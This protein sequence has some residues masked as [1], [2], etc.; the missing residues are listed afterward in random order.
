MAST[1]QIE[2][3]KDLLRISGTPLLSGLPESARVMPDPL[4]I[5]VYLQFTAPSPQARL[6]FQAGE[7]VESLHFTCCH[8]Y[9]PYWMTI[10]TGTRGGQVPVETQFLL[11]E[12]PD[13]TVVL[14]VPLLNGP[15]RCS[16]QGTGEDGLELVAES[17]DPAVVTD[18]VTGL[19]IAAGSDPYSLVEESAGS[20]MQHMGTGRLRSEKPLPDFIDQFG[21]CTWDAF[22]Q[23]V[24][25]EKVRQGLES[26]VRGGIL[27]RL[28]ILDDGWQ[29]EQSMPTGERRLTS[30]AANDKFPGGLAPTV[31]MA[32]DEFGVETFLVWHA[33]A[34]YW[35]GVHPPSFPQ[36]DIQPTARSFSPGILHY[37]PDHNE[38]WWGSVIGVV[39]P[40][41]ID[42]F[43]Q[44][45]HRSLRQQGVDGVKVDTQASLEAV[46]AGRG[47]RVAMMQRY[48]EALE[49][50]AQVHFGGRLINCMSLS[51]D[52]LY[53]TLSSSLTRTST[54]F[55]PE[56]P[57]THGLHLYV[58]AQVSLWFG[59][60]VHPDW[61]MFQSGH[62]WGAYHA[63]ARAIS[64]GPVYVSDKPCTH[65]FDLL[66]KLVLP[67]GRILR[68][69][70]TARPTRDCLFHDPTQ[71]DVLLKIFNLNHQAGVIG[72][73]NARYTPL[74]AND[75]AISG[76]ISPADVPD[77]D[78]ERFAIYAHNIR[79][80]RVVE[81]DEQW[82][83][84]LPQAGFEIFTVVPVDQ[85]VAPLGLV[86]L[87]NSAGAILEKGFITQ[88]IYRIRTR[89]AGHF[90]V[91]CSRSPIR[92]VAHER[93]NRHPRTT[94]LPFSYVPKT[95]WL[96]F[97]LNVHG[98]EI[99]DIE[100]SA[101]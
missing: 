49:G 70:Q 29:S 81:R 101:T 89:G 14:L 88:E 59:E 66:R 10:Q 95:S 71:E 17:G 53:S 86:E 23:E 99:I 33:L 12:L 18:T 58:N 20:I 30:F 64:G 3:T 2:L 68:A 34:G 37:Y 76:S 56:R 50:S 57:H 93:N 83:L 91:W 63:A 82:E 96:E 36:Y 45:Y 42:R 92:V 39:S 77:M 80:L 11:L 85:G 62:P 75:S 28:L 25:H 46:S 8:R 7:L 21:W 15:F 79:E 69:L 84:A 73:F 13:H 100:F 87:F 48:H 41:S 65:D 4:G 55:W 31:R 94:D 32:K 22:Y 27:P 61:D 54:D 97:D 47:G 6:V 1:F 67:D 40:K 24:S 38:K 19:F 5:G 60:F 26:F 35:G 9:E 43:Y 72:V 74:R 52:M 51:N 98:Q 90:A 78:G 44:D 16:L